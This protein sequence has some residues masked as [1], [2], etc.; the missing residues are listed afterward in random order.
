M[1]YKQQITTINYL[2]IIVK[3]SLTTSE[4]N[5]VDTCCCS[6]T[7]KGYERVGKAW[8]EDLY[9]LFLI[10]ITKEINFSGKYYDFNNDID[11]TFD[12]PR[13]LL[14][15]FVFSI[16]VIAYNLDIKPITNKI[17]QRI[18]EKI[19]NQIKEQLLEDDNWF[20]YGF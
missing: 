8:I 11:I 18:L 20:K 2:D 13:E 12:I 19:N 10:P 17:A 1:E 15:I 14:R 6:F 3:V 5:I 16:G 9:H 7:R 4:W